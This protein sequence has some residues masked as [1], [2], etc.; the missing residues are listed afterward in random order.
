MRSESEKQ[1]RKEIQGEVKKK[2]QEDFEKSLPL[3][4][5]IFLDLFESL[6][7]NLEE[8]CDHQMTL[9]IQFLEQNKVEDVDK[10]IEW[11]N[12]KGGHCDCEVIANVEPQFG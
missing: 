12:E 10:V 4:R 2:A 8:N 11:L 6:N 1:R 3:G 5:Q 9:T 7:F